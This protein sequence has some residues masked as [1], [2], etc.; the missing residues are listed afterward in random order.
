ML[1]SSSYDVSGLEWVLWNIVQ[2]NLK[3]QVDTSSVAGHPHLTDILA[4]DNLIPTAN[5]SL[6]EMTVVGRPPIPVIDDDQ[7]AITISVPASEH[8]HTGF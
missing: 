5:K 3:V 2:P 7:L 4:S 1:G 8:H 6:G